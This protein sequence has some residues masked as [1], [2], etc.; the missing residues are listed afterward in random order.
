MASG[1]GAGLA[2]VHAL[3]GAVLLRLQCSRPKP[4]GK[5]N[6]PGWAALLVAHSLA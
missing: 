5:R 2:P 4:A 1:G 3:E 6:A